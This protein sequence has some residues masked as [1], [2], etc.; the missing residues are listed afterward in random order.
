MANQSLI[1]YIFLTLID[2][3][4][5]MLHILCL[6]IKIY[7]LNMEIKFLILFKNHLNY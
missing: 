7:Q 4:N 2:L 1:L 5:I 3:T 6:K